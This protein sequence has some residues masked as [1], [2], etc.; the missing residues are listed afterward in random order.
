MSYNPYDYYRNGQDFR[1]HDWLPLRDRID[2][3]TAQINNDYT[4]A[5]GAGAAQLAREPVDT[6]YCDFSARRC[7][8]NAEVANIKANPAR[9]WAKEHVASDKEQFVTTVYIA[10]HER[11]HARWT[12]FDPSDYEVTR[13]GGLDSN[14]LKKGKNPAKQFDAILHTVVNILEDERIERLIERDYKYLRGYLKRGAKSFLR[15]IHMKEDFE[16]YPI[17]DNPALVIGWILR[18]RVLDRV[19]IV[20]PCP[21]NANL[22]EKLKLV[23]P[24]V[25]EAFVAPNTKE[26]VR[27][28]REIIKLLE[29][30]EFNDFLK[31]IAQMLGQMAGKRKGG[32][33]AK[34]RGKGQSSDTG[35]VS[36]GSLDGEGG[37]DKDDMDRDRSGDKD[38]DDS[39]GPGS[40]LA[41]D[42][43]D[44]E[45]VSSG[46]TEAI[47][48]MKKDKRK[49]PG[50]YEEVLNSVRP[51]LNQA[52][53][54]FKHEK[55]R[56]GKD[57][58]RTGSRLDLRRAMRKDPEPFKTPA[59]PQKHGK[60]SVSLVIDESGSMSGHKEFEAKRVS[61]LMFE[62]LR[63]HHD[64]RITLAPTGALLAESSDGEL[65]K[66]YIAG[67]GS[68]TDTKFHEVMEREMKLLA[69]NNKSK[70]RYCILIADGESGD[71]DQNQC[72]KLVTTYRKR[73]VR[74]FGVGLDLM[75]SG[76]EFLRTTFGDQFYI[77]L[78]DAS[79][80]TPRMATL[81][82]ALAIRTKHQSR[83]Q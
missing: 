28:A 36:R 42:D 32:D 70:V 64:V 14:A 50:A 2:L 63:H 29:I 13:T 53:S 77:S 76:E 45:L 83:T 11:A 47:N 1:W 57:Y 61:M 3:K 65:G 75:S 51:Y 80:L 6:G 68:H 72:N 40:G 59:P 55:V 31:Q 4:L 25:D 7:W 54:L 38:E 37:G 34:G 71:Y 18:K 41:D 20:E 23:Q 19:G 39:Y 22:Q 73:G 5:F 56:P 79:E 52:A 48:K 66:A 8:V 78:K 26:V 43:I 9:P 17:Q 35:T 81:L 33:E 44:R 16:N 49:V 58:D 15:K 74:A 24:L 62:A 21:L 12:D 30:N 10:A 67:Y 82:R 46:Y 69:Q 27:L 60:M